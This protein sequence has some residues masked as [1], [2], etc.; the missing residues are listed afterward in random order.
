MGSAVAI[1]SNGGYIGVP[2]AHPHSHS[3]GFLNPRDRAGLVLSRPNLLKA[4]FAGLGGLTLPGLLRAQDGRAKPGRS[5]GKSVILLW[6]TGGPSQ[7]D[8]LDP[9]PSR[10]PE[11]R[12]PFGVTKTKL[13]G[14]L[15]CEH[16]PK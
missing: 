6:M 9:K 12:G 16:L 2:M 1:P 10:P 5:P 3:F 14:V 8:T 15:I 7:I 13:P 11:N 4:G